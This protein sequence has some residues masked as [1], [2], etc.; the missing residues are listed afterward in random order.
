[1]LKQFFVTNTLKAIR[2]MI[3]IKPIFLRVC[4]ACV[5]PFRY[6]I[7]V[8]VFLLIPVFQVLFSIRRKLIAISRPARNKMMLVVANR[9]TVHT[10]IIVVVLVVSVLNLQTGVVRAESFG[11]ES[12]MYGLVAE[13][14]A[15]I[16]QEFAGQ[17]S[18][19]HISP[20]R[21]REQTGVSE[22]LFSSS[23]V[24]ALDQTDLN[25]LYGDAVTASEETTLTG[26]TTSETYTI[27]SGDS[28]SVIASKYDLSINTLLW[29]NNLSVGSVLRPGNTLVILPVDGVKHVVKSGD[30][31][32]Q[33]SKTYDVDQATI[34][35][36]NGRS[37]SDVLSIGDELIIPGGEVRAVARS[38]SSAISNLISSAPSGAVSPSI[39]SGSAGSGYMVWPTDMSVITQYFS[40]KHNGL[41]IDC[42]YDNNNYAADDGYVTIS[43]WQGGY[44]YLVEIDHGNG[45]VTR[46]GHHASLYVTQGQYVNAGE[47]LGLCGTT[48]NS[49][50]THL[51]LEVIVNG[52][53]KNP[54]EYIRR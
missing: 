39:S 52:V 22:D 20:I 42:K 28:L 32:T 1:M 37:T 47:A 29:A 27:Q 54:L 10:I 36:Y 9:F 38:T 17:D 26:R 44:G 16:V 30:T 25:I 5:L 15:E 4:I 19:I 41:D 23:A 35:A 48:G 34:L 7:K 53:R 14:K 40:W 13:D 33:I 45:I 50:G 24:L 21:Y 8:L 51:H 43:G 46:Y 6:L 49:S 31:I 18:A 12:I 3:L 11:R 2:A